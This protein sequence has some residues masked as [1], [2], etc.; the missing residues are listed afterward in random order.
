MLFNNIMTEHKIS[1]NNYENLRNKLN[2]FFKIIDRLASKCFVPLSVGGWIKTVDDAT[3]MIRRGADKVIINSAAYENENLINSIALRHGRQ[4][5]IVSIDTIL[6]DKGNRVVVIDRAT[7][8]TN[9]PPLDWAKKVVDRGAG[10]I[11]YNSVEHDGNRNGYDLDTIRM[12]TD[13]LSIPIIAFGG[14]QTWEHLEYGITEANADAVA[15]ANILHYTEH[16]V[17]KAKQFL[18]SKNLQFRSNN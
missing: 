9:I 11:F 6:D 18:L 4:A 1:I 5:C 8:K 15:A 12:L 13:H 7:R 10:E 2:E 17:L 16:S 3:E 14:V